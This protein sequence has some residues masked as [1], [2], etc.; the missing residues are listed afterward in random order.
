MDFNLALLNKWRWRILKGDN[1]VWYDVLRA[2]YGD[3]STTVFCGDSKAHSSLS[4]SLWWKDLIN[5]GM[6]T[7][8]DPMANHCKFEIGNGFS[9]PFW[10]GRW[11]EG[12]I[13]SHEYPD[14]YLLSCFKKVS[15]GAM[16]GWHNGV[17]G[18]GDFGI[19]SSFLTTDIRLSLNSLRSS[20]PLMAFGSDKG[21]KVGWLGTK[22][23]EFSVT[24]CYIFYASFRTPFGP[25]NKNEELVAKIWKLAVP[26]KIKIFGWRLFVNRLPTKDLLKIRGIPIPLNSLCCSF[27]EAELESRNHSFF[28]CK[29]VDLIW[30]DIVIWVG[31][32]VGKEEDCLANFLDWY[33]FCKVNK[34]RE[35]KWGLIWMAT[36]WS[37]WLT[38]NGMCFRNDG[39]NV[40]NTVWNVKLLAWKWSFLGENSNSNYSFYEFVKDPL[41]FLS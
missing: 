23:G 33:S 2:R 6:A 20:L 39:W 30:N 19:K 1:N 26:F 38:R 12:N 3:I 36:T 8:R 5:I 22:G 40:D 13:L 18:W 10:E 41:L 17:W 9:I 16:G 32:P 15:V 31:K 29:V 28:N 37:I 27:C 24:S 25:C 4:K 11:T 7:N 21:D 14:L 35:S 34:V